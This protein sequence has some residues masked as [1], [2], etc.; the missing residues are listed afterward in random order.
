MAVACGAEREAQNGQVEVA[1]GAEREAQAM[2]PHV[3]STHALTKM[4]FIW[5]DPRPLAPHSSAT[6]ERDISRG[7]TANNFP[8][9]CYIASTSFVCAPPRLLTHSVSQLGGHPTVDCLKVVA[10]EV[11]V[12]LSLECQVTVSAD[13]E[14]A[15]GPRTHLVLHHNT[16][17]NKAGS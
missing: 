1:R 9:S 16:G 10:V 8:F 6:P 2:P 17:G 4:C 13:H 11:E 15:E 3:T 12:R 5:G 7:K 14:D